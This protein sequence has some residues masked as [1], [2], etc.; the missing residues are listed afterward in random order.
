M[1]QVLKEILKERGDGIE[2]YLYTNENILCEEPLEASLKFLKLVKA[3]DNFTIFAHDDFDGVSAAVL[4]S[5]L[6]DKYNKHYTVFFPDRDKETY[7]ILPKHIDKFI[8]Q[9]IK[10]IITV[11]NGIKSIAG[12]EYANKKG[13]NVL[14]TDHH[15]PPN[16][17]PPADVIVNPVVEKNRTTFVG[18]GVVFKILLK[19]SCS[20]LNNK[21]ILALASLATIIDRG[22]LIYENRVIVK[23]GLAYIIGTNRVL[24]IWSQISG[25][26]SPYPSEILKTSGVFYNI[27]T[28][29]LYKILRNEISLKETEKIFINAFSKFKQF[30]EERNKFVEL[31]TERSRVV[32][33]VVVSFYPMPN[34]Y[35]GTVASSISKKMNMPAIIIGKNLGYLTGEIRGQDSLEILKCIKDLLKDFGGHPMAAGFTIKK[36]YTLEDFL[37]TIQKINCPGNQKNKSYS[38]KELPIKL[39]NDDFKILAPFGEGNPAP[40]FFSKETIVKK[41]NDFY[42]EN[43]KLICKTVCLE[44]CF[45][46]KYT[47]DDE[48]NPILISIDN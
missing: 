18:A 12:V 24:D 11:D 32:N 42:I 40:V 6:L 37:K 28:Y 41:D 17:L 35:L 33:N 39:L 36:N 26:K 27:S 44:G 25:L 31:A 15:V 45:W 23:Q 46:I 29:I 38:L 43:K 1:N 20:F 8:D 47:I 34:R 30:N 13:I 7:G 2:K 10:N 9:G 14:I 3:R 4:L 22:D 48:A 5:F 16:P 19:D 21:Y